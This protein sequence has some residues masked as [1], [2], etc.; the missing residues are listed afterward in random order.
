M[1]RYYQIK[2]YFWRKGY[3]GTVGVVT[4]IHDSGLRHIDSYFE[5]IRIIINFSA[6]KNTCALTLRSATYLETKIYTI[7]ISE[8]NL[9]IYT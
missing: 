4:D 9:S 2:F 3:K 6:S 1:S 8:L 5:I 7:Y